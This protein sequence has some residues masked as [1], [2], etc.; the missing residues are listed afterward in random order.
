VEHVTAGDSNDLLAGEFFCFVLDVIHDYN[1]GPITQKGTI[2]HNNGSH[3]V[4]ERLET[5]V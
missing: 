4:C 2:P 1:P 3:K 5:L